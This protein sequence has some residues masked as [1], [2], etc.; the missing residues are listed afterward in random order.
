[1]PPQNGMVLEQNKHFEGP[2]QLSAGRRQG[3]R[4][5]EEARQGEKR[6]L[7]DGRYAGRTY[8]PPKRN[9]GLRLLLALVVVAGRFDLGLRANRHDEDQVELCEKLGKSAQPS[10]MTAH[11]RFPMLEPFVYGGLLLTSCACRAIQ[12]CSMHEFQ[13]ELVPAKR[14]LLVTSARYSPR[15]TL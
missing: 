11:T 9:L 14:V 15:S 13:S 1:M 7:A 6:P 8:R 4:V 2:I 12:I 3:H 5:G 10:V